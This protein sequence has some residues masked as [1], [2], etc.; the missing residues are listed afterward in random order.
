MELLKGILKGVFIS[1]I[2]L[3]MGCARNFDSVISQPDGVA[4]ATKLDQD[5]LSGMFYLENGQAQSLEK[6]ADK[7]LLI[8][9]VG[10]K[11]WS[12]RIETEKLKTL[13]VDKGLP[14]QI[15]LLSIMNNVDP[16]VITEWF[17]EIEPASPK[18]ILGSESALDLYHQYFSILKTPSILYFNPQSQV[19][20]R[21]Q[22]DPQNKKYL[23]SLEV[24]QKETGPWY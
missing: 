14:T 15:Y 21:W 4:Q 10:E 8:F 12:C 18:W 13:M 2:W 23:P 3:V 6:Y 17:E 1:V 16:S 20:M 24:L 9:F 11:C 22:D 7:P 5:F 19:L